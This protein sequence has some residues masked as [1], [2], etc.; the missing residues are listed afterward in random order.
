MLNSLRLRRDVVSLEAFQVSDVAAMAQR[1]IPAIVAQ[2]NDFTGQFKAEQ[3]AVQFTVNDRE[4]DGHLREHTYAN[5]TPLTAYVP[6]GLK[7]TYLDYYQSLLPAI[8]RAASIVDRV[9]VPY[10]VFLSNL[11]TNHTA[12][13][14]SRTHSAE[15]KKMAE[16]RELLN[17][18]IGRC[19]KVGSN[20][21]ELKYG[22]VLERNADWDHV[23]SS[24]RS[25][26]NLINSVNRKNVQSK[27][28]ECDELLG[29]IVAKIKRNEMDSIT[30]Q[31]VKSLAEGAYQVASELEF[32][33]ASWYRATAYVECVK[34]T[35]D[36]VSEVFK[37]K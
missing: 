25:V 33:S 17:T 29:I 13:L 28:Q 8:E 15:W 34:R 19:F 1:A 14:D 11:V 32:Y 20:R 3:P 37:R 31:V 16:A 6:E 10:A 5:L 4:F 36:H 24:A 12:Q 18:S 2:F 27:I 21:S 26:S 35:S 23:F 30:P 22:D 7:V 9:L